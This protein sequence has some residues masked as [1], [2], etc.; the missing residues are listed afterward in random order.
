MTLNA[1]E[2]ALFAAQNERVRE[3]ETWLAMF[4]VRHGR[5]M[6][7]GPGYRYVLCDAHADQARQQLQ[8]HDMSVDISYD[9]ESASFIL[10]AL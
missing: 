6:P 8:V 9:L 5:A 4:I 7:V 2:M 1:G 3:L 10:V